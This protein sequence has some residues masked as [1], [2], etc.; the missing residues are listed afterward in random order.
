LQF[1]QKGTNKAK[2]KQVGK[3]G[4]LVVEDVKTMND[5]FRFLSKMQK[6]ILPAEVAI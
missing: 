4:I 5:L 2:L 1:L 3:N 6:S